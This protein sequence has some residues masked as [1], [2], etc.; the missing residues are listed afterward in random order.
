LIHKYPEMVSKG[1]IALASPA[2]QRDLASIFLI[3]C[4]GQAR[5]DPPSPFD[6]RRA[7]AG[8]VNKRSPL[9]DWPEY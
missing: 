5:T 9:A 8:Q 3:F 1:Q 7:M 6:K 4:T 2:G